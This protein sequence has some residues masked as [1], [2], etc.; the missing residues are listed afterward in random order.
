MS[1]QQ[2]EARRP[3]SAGTAGCARRSAA[4]PSVRAWPCSGR[5]STSSPRS[6]TTAPAARSPRRPPS[7]PTLRGGATGNVDAATKV[8]ELVAERAKA[9]GVDQ[10]VFDRGGFRYHGRVA[11]LAD[12][13]REAGLEF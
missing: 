13:A 3:A 7:R 6:S 10:V 11:A 4:P 12:A 2:A 8:G 5:T 9:A 1:D